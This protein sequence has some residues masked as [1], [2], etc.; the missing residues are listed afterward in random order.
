MNCSVLS[1]LSLGGSLVLKAKIAKSFVMNPAST[2]STTT[3]SNVW[4]HFSR[5]LL[6][7]SLALCKNPLVHAKIE[8][9]EFVE[10]SF[11]YWWNLKCLVTVP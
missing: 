2:V 9:I 10:V 8:A 7:S 1:H 6:L 5:S 11:P 3:F 4:H